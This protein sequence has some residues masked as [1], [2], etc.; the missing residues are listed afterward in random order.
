M[1]I[2][3]SSV[4]IIAL[5]IVLLSSTGCNLFPNRD[6]AI[7]VSLTQT[8]EVKAGIRM[9]QTTVATARLE[10]E[11]T[12]APSENATDTPS[13]VQEP[14]VQ[15]AVEADSRSSAQIPLPIYYIDTAG[16]II[17]LEEDGVTTTQI[18][19]EPTPIDEFDISP[20]GTRIVYVSD[21]R[22]IEF[23][24]I[25]GIRYPLVI[26]ELFRGDDFEGRIS[27]AISSPKYSP[28]G[29][30]I[31]FGL[32]GVH[33]VDSG[34]NISEIVE[35]NPLLHSDPYPDLS[36]PTTP[37]PEG[38]IRFFWPVAWSPD[39]TKLLV[40]ANYFPEGSRLTIFDI[41]QQTLIDIIG[42]QPETVLCCDA[43]WS[44]DSQSI[45]IASNQIAYGTPGLSIVNAKTGLADIL[46]RGFPDAELNEDNPLVYLRGPHILDNGRI[47][48]FISSQTDYAQ[49]PLY[50]MA[51][52]NPET[53]DRLPLRVDGNSLSGDMLWAPDGSGAVVVEV[54]KA[55]QT[56]PTGPMI[57]LPANGESAI[58]L[59]IAGRS[60]K[61]ATPNRQIAAVENTSATDSISS[62]DD[63]DASAQGG[64]TSDAA[65]EPLQTI[66]PDM[67]ADITE[68]ETLF[69][70]ELAE[71]SVSETG[72]IGANVIPIDILG[73]GPV[74]DDTAQASLW[75]VHSYGIRT[76]EPD[77]GHALAIYEYMKDE[78]TVWT[79]RARI[80]LDELSSTDIIAASPDYLNE[81]SVQQVYVEPSRVWIGINGGVGAHSSTYNLL[82][83][84]GETLK[85]EAE[86]FSSSPGAGTLADINS[87]G[88][89]D[90]LLDATDYYVFCY[91]CS[92]RLIDFAVFRWD[93]TSEGMLPVKLS[94]LSSDAPSALTTVNDLAL[95]LAANG[96]WKDAKST[97]MQGLQLDVYERSA[98]P[99][100]DWNVSLIQLIADARRDNVNAR[101][102]GYPLLDNIFYGDYDAAVDLMRAY[103][104]EDIFTLDSPLIK[105]TVAESWEGVLADWIITISSPALETIPDLATAHFI[106]G[107]GAYL[108]DPTD[109]VATEDI[110]K[111]LELAPDDELFESSIDFLLG[112]DDVVSAEEDASDD[113]ATGANEDDADE[114]LVQVVPTPTPVPA[115]TP[116]PEPTAVVEPANAAPAQDDTGGDAADAS[117][118]AVALIEEFTAFGLLNVRQG[119]GLEFEVIGQL[120]PGETA[121]VV[122]YSGSGDDVWWQIAYDA[123]DGN[124]GWVYGSIDYEEDSAGTDAQTA[125]TQDAA[126]P[127]AAAPPAPSPAQPAS[128]SQADAPIT[129]TQPSQPAPPAPVGPGRIFYSA[130]DGG[131][132]NVY[133]VNPNGDPILVVP[134]A[135]DP[136]M[137]SNGVR[138]AFQSKKNDTL[139]LGGFDVGSGL[140]LRFSR[141]IED[142]L[143]S[144]NSAG[145]RIVFGSNREGDR[146]WRVY[147]TWADDNN[148]ASFLAFG[149]D[150]DWHPTSDMVIYKGC[151]EAGASCG[152]WQI[153]ANGGSN[154]SI[155]TV[156]SDSRPVW[157]P[158]GQLVVFM[159]SDRDGNWEL[160]TLDVASKT[161]NRLTNSPALDGL[162]AISP[163]GSQVVFYSTR[164]GP[165]GLWT[166]P[167][168]GGT[169]QP[170]VPNIGELPDWGIQGVDWVP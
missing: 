11:T 158:N 55:N 111:A 101:D 19:N 142:G 21:N 8:A 75:L 149:Q 85:Q 164:G 132:Y 53:G 148:N 50:V 84:D 92:V 87:D 121:E 124:Q 5:F 118:S 16:Q 94:T 169:A 150:P 25:G 29:S 44:L 157:A 10:P 95:T 126:Q 97:I 160:Y 72:I 99:D 130:Y 152:L 77:Q 56:A 144:W 104:P 90:L 63:S 80:S 33:V 123:G 32:N 125:T 139:G 112:Q 145:N 36:D 151:D 82:S 162:P 40:H 147:V 52:V 34:S 134:E 81:Q 18:T 14:S 153:N 128:D 89:P 61:L 1:P 15:A 100:F 155:T 129:D 71:G 64:S 131:R 135:V 109:P 41:E 76:F 79:E 88:T 102:G 57:W 119:P 30:Q 137:N 4:L 9:T 17:R 60:P 58:L 67:Q 138:L 69:L 66:A 163:D 98:Y 35:L 165:W 114:P 54:V 133:Q 6:V 96:L 117:D 31:A 38:S 159:S 107:W 28:D 73:E 116:T 86:G 7:G 24:T 122:G 156:P 43:V 74:T 93:E 27:K 65:P 115:E 12:P 23:D 20:S 103:P 46:I 78:A 51:E 141:F 136:T 39:S 106:R 68:L 127:A 108:V 22:L 70:A 59:P 168:T 166:I 154:A 13:N 140:T 45:Y 110:V 49:I 120:Q 161:V 167:I 91:A 143:A 105:D 26:G 146:R 48:S 47:Y 3:K 37:F 42:A 62:P 83:F 113:S 2:Q 170:L